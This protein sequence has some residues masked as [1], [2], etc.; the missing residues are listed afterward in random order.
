MGGGGR[1]RRS[2]PRITEHFSL[3]HMNLTCAMVIIDFD[4]S[5]LTES[6][7][8]ELRTYAREVAGIKAPPPR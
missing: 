7:N 3:P 4:P 8:F 6:D 2:L 1:L 5:Q